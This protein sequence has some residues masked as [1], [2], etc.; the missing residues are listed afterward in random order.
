[1][2]RTILA[3]TILG[4]LAGGCGD[5]LNADWTT[6]QQLN[7]GIVYILP[8]IQGVDYHYKNI[9]NGLAGA[10]VHCAIKI[11]P[12]GCRIPGINLMINET[13]AAS[14]RDWGRKIAEEIAAYQKDYPGRRVY[15]IGQSGGSGVAVFTAEALA[16]TGAEPV[17][18]L[19]LLDASLSSDY[20]LTTALSMC[21]EGIVNFYNLSDVA[22]LEVGTAVFGN[23][24][25]GHG[26]SAGR[27]GFTRTYPR[28]YEVQV[29][30]DMVDDFADP[31]FAD[32]S[33]AFAA[34]Y[35]APW[36]IDV[37]WP[38]SRMHLERE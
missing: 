13:A 16:K 26:A 35:I 14:D 28:L 38:P 33:K 8:G 15:I 17:E 6:P 9:R 10:G 24:D 18:G 12:W 23:V 36:V 19:V 32:C 31:H 1:M 30:K 27:T 3:T 11:H 34:Q 22:L 7:A 37:A 2:K 29:T 4:M 25:G 5:T 20:D 21:T